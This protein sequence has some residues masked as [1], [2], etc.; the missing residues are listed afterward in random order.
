MCSTHQNPHNIDFYVQC[1]VLVECWLKFLRDSIC[2]SMFRGGPPVSLH[3]FLLQLL[4]VIHRPSFMPVNSNDVKQIGV[5]LSCI[6]Y[7]HFGY[8]CLVP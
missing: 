4:Q 3:Q 7:K 1:A 2:P 5:T 6:I 8:P